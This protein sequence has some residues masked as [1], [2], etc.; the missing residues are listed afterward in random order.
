MISKIA[1]FKAEAKAGGWSEGTSL[2]HDEMADECGMSSAQ[3]ALTK[4]AIKENPDLGIGLSTKRGMYPW[5]VVSL[6][7]HLTSTATETVHSTADG[8][9]EENLW[10]IVRDV[11]AA[12]WKS[13][14][15]GTAEG[16]AMKPYV[17]KMKGFLMSL[18]EQ[19]VGDE[20]PYQ[21][22]EVL[23]AQLAAFGVTYNDES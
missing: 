10:R 1:I 20:D 4:R 6:D 13:I 16:R 17:N 23:E 5:T 18:R 2:R 21:L 9:M 8:K 14:H 12:Q 3:L 22:R 11:P 15:K 7:T 19:T